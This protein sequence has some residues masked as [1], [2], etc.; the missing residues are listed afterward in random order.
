MK[1]TAMFWQYRYFLIRQTYTVGLTITIC[2]E[3]SRAR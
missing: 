1:P 3:L 2:S